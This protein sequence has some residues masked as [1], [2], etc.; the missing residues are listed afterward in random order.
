VTKAL[1]SNS[2]ITIAEEYNGINNGRLKYKQ[3]PLKEK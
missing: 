2:N 3:T 1:E